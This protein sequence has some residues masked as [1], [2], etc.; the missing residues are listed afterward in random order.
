MPSL[1]Y[2]FPHS[3]IALFVAANWQCNF[4]VR[5]NILREMSG[6]HDEMSR[7]N[8]SKRAPATDFSN[9]GGGGSDR[10]A[11]EAR[12]CAKSGTFQKHFQAALL[13]VALLAAHLLMCKKSERDSL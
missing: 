8:A 13:K 5:L 1:L 12:K 2:P 4:P 6:I 9:N 3:L 10:G 11:I 7:N